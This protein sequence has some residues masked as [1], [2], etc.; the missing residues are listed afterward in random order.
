[1][2]SFPGHALT[3][4]GSPLG[5]V[6]LVASDGGGGIGGSP[7]VTNPTDRRAFC[8]V[9]AIVF[10]LWRVGA[11]VSWAKHPEVLPALP[12]DVLFHQISLEDVLLLAPTPNEPVG[13]TT[14][15]P[16][17]VKR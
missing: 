13:F 5:I 3:M 2:A 10:P 8:R 4:M 9:C 11:H 12:R 16:P 14:V 17:V 6:T 15:S 1:M 7:E